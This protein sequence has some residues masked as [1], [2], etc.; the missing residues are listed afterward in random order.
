MAVA[1]AASWTGDPL[2]EW[3]RRLSAVRGRPAAYRKD[4]GSDRPKAIAVV[5]EQGRSSPC[6]DD[7]SHAVA[8]MLKRR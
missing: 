3:L 5:E 8:P 6:M 7:L 4:G 1:V 2:A